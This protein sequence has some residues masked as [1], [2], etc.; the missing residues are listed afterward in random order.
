MS[1][2][3]ILFLSALDFKEKSIQVIR[4]TPEAYVKDDWD[5]NYVV[6]R[7]NSKYDNYYYE[8]EINI[9]GV[10]LIREYLPLTNLINKYGSNR[11]SRRILQKTAYFLAVIKLYKLGNK[12]LKEKKIDVIYGYEIYGVLAVNLLKFFGKLKGIKIISRFQGTFY[13]Y[14]Y[15]N[16]LYMKMVASLDHCLAL[17]L[18]SDLCIMTDDGTQGDKALEIMKSKNLK[19]YKF[20][21]NGVDE[22]KLDA[23]KVIKLKEK[24]N[25]ENDIVFLSISRLEYWKRVDR[26]LQVLAILKS[27]YKI[28][29]FKYFVIGEG[30]EKENL[31]KLSK[32]LGIKNEVIFVGAIPNLKVK[33][34]LNIADFFLSTYDSSNVGNPLLEAIRA[35]KIIFTLN[36]GDTKR[37]VQH[38]KNGF[39]YDINKN[40]YENIAKGINEVI[41]NKILKDTILKNIKLTEKENLLTWDERMNNEIK[42]VKKLFV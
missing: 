33:E 34:Y 3:T 10:N 30:V 41:K 14:Y 29:N 12:I 24:L 22:Q 23:N 2:K 9:E 5:V 7:D 28:E 20:F 1:H 21:P 15:Y 17:Y 35:N 18:P 32:E 6:I 26:S 25:P 19:N 36:N 11:V 40:L 31:M 16:K 42:E 39:I 38:K 27:K 13:S 4:K 8:Q 37:W